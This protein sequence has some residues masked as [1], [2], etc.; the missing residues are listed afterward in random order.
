M[1]NTFKSA[2]NIFAQASDLPPERHL[3]SW[4]RMKAA[5]TLLALT[6][7]AL[8]T[9][10]TSCGTSTPEAPASASSSTAEASEPVSEDFQGDIT[11]PAQARKS[12][13]LTKA[14][15][16]I[17]DGVTTRKDVIR[18]LGLFYSKGTNAAGQATGLWKFSPSAS[19][20][21]AWIPGSA[22]IPGAIITYYQSVTVV[23]D[24]NDVVVSHS[25]LESTKEKTGLGF[26]YGG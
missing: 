1:P 24:A 21:K 19:T 18:K 20:A 16:Q 3:L 10:L 2:R 14:A 4:L 15:A 17:Q 23:F 26:S 9:A 7:L 13:H 5:P 12:T 6:S 8:I 22:F 11:N 25:F